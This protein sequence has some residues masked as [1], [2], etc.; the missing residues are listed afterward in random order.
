MTLKFKLFE[1]QLYFGNELVFELIY[2]GSF[3]VMEIRTQSLITNSEII[4]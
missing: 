2:A 3:S 1:K 4:I